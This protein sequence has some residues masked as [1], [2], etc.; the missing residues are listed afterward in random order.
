MKIHRMTATF[1]MLQNE[2]LELGDGLNIIYSPNE[3][4]KSTWCAFIKAML[5]GIDSS[6]REKGGIKPDKVKF[7][8]WSGASM[9]GIMDIEYEDAEITLTRQGRDSA[10]MRDFTAT[11]TGTSNIVKS[12]D[13]SAAGE[14]ILGISK[15]VFERSAFIGQGKVSVGASP[16][17]ERRISA[18][19][20]TGEEKSSVTEAEERLKAAM[21]RRRFNKSGRLPEI[22]REL[23]ETRR[24]L[25]ESESELKKGEDLKK[26]KREALERRDALLDKVAE[27][28][29]KT[30]RETLDRLAQSRDSIK[31][32][33]TE[34][35][36]LCLHLEE[37]EKKLDEGVFGRED[38]KKCRQKLNVDKKKLAAIDNE[39]KHGG[40]LIFN[41]AVLA[42]LLIVAAV[43]IN[44][45]YYIPAAVLCALAVV[46]AGRLHIL[47]KDYK[48]A[49][50]E[51]NAIF[52][53]YK[54]FTVDGM[55]QALT[56][57]EELYKEY[58]EILEKQTRAG[59]KL[60]EIMDAQSAL[61]TT[62]LKEL[63]FTEGG[64]EAVKYKKLL[65][66]AETALRNIREESA[67]WEGRQSLLKDPFELTARID[68]LTAEY[69]KL[70]MEYEALNL[71]LNTLI[72]AGDE[73]SH[74]ITPRLS[75]RTA[76]IF[77]KLTASKYDAILLDRE[78]K[79]S[80]RP[81]G[82]TLPREMSFLSAGAV[83]QLYL[84][85]RLAICELALPISK[86][87]P[88][89]LDDAL[90]NFDDERCL[91]ALELLR[92]MARYR[93]IILFT[94]HRREA[95]LMAGKPNVRI[96][97]PIKGQ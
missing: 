1:G 31:A 48:L 37:I 34:Y 41:A 21:R 81:S 53:E 77:S 33:E 40:S 12:I 54:C 55:E 50:D 51:R 13:P 85:V 71:A 35:A 93:Q 10:P 91:Y 57:H 74:R 52:E 84:A 11:Y 7:A 26:A 16:E 32:Q 29:K 46:Q 25:A 70:S 68:E 20:Q 36:K 82:D 14:T 24:M 5:Y 95:D 2:T 75:A 69:E 97:V 56:L 87:C 80:A 30:R 73:I 45:S 43:L 49:E 38:P 22:E 15:D 47:K 17:L 64:T 90:V 8:P 42:A 76:E 3:S 94:C 79:A 89:I 96:A 28:R 63:D 58:E 86:Q 78:L 39:A 6:A 83:D 4:G 61:E 23:E 27:E 72:E 92:D 59:K 44:F 18:I 19:V 66:D 9:S 62:L 65:D 67:A 60:S 88:I